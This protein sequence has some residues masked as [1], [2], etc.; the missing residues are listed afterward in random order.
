ML[1]ASSVWF[2]EAPKALSDFPPCACLS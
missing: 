2:K 1:R